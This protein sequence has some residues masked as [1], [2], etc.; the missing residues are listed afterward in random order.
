MHFP[1][2]QVLPGKTRLLI[3]K[4][5]QHFKPKSL[6]LTNAILK[7]AWAGPNR[8]G[9]GGQVRFEALEWNRVG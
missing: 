7:G 1:I 5:V 8:C 9:G 4:M 6:L 2:T 3:C